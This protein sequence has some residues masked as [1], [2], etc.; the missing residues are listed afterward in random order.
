MASLAQVRERLRQALPE[1]GRFRALWLRT[2]SRR[3]LLANLVAKGWTEALLR[4]VLPGAYDLY[5]LLG[6]LAYG[7]P[8]V[9]LGERAA[10]VQDPRFAPLLAG[11]RMQGRLPLEG[12]GLL[13]ELAQILYA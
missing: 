5:D 2:G 3:A 10:R 12:D 11:Y 1:E 9:P 4:R 7:W 13:E 6:H 8:L